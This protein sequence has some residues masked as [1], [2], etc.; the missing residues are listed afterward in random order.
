MNKKL[1]PTLLALALAASFGANAVVY[2]IENIDEL[3]KVNGTISNHRSGSGV[4]L[5]D[6]DVFIG[7]A[8]GKY[9]PS[10]SQD[11]LAII[12]NNSVDVAI[13]AIVASASNSST[14]PTR[15]V[16]TIPD[17]NNVIFEFDDQFML[18]TNWN[19]AMAIN[20]EELN[21][22]LRIQINIRKM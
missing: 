18:K 20:L 1:Q 17:A 16:K 13:T 3:Y 12:D 10:L 7:G 14:N 21:K 19:W 9:S 15:A 4:T 8:S 11:D 5:N 2:K 22:F 6:N